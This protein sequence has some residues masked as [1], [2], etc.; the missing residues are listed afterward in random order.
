M[1]V[2]IVTSIFPSVNMLL[3]Y[4]AIIN[5]ETTAN[6]GNMVFSGQKRKNGLFV[7]YTHVYSHP[8]NYMGT[9]V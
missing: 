5:H 4:S 1:I 8:E 6:D 9:R 2:P 3:Q 7:C